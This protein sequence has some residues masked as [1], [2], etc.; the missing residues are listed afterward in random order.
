MLINEKKVEEGVQSTEVITIPKVTT[1]DLLTSDTWN[2]MVRA[3][4]SKTDRAGDTFA[5][6]LTINSKLTV[7]DNL[8]TKTATVSDKLTVKTATVDNLTVTN[9]VTALTVDNL[10]VT[11]PVT[12]L[13]VDNLT[14][15][16]ALSA[17]YLEVRS[18]V[19]RY[20]QEYYYYSIGNRNKEKPDIKGETGYDK[21][22]IECSIYA[23]KRIVA[24]EFNA[25]SDA[26]IKQNLHRSNAAADLATLM[27]LKVTDY[28]MIDTISK[29]NRVSKKLIAQ[30][31]AAVYPNAVSY[32]KDF[33]PNI[34]QLAQIENGFVT[35]SNP[36]LTIGDKV[37]LIFED[38][39]MEVRVTEIDENGFS[40]LAEQPESK[41]PNGAV[42]VFGKE[43]NDF[44]TLDYDA[45]TMLNTSATQAL[46]KQIN[47]LETSHAALKARFEALEMGLQKVRI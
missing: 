26:R 45:I 46:V 14:V 28:T 27:Q 31:V 30:E 16:N 7:D 17:G 12:A 25:I 8:T 34:Y 20:Q 29:G 10:T 1:G 4:N 38:Q 23:S 39:Q 24:S 3:I 9:P 37:R 41:L 43:V 33:I 42:F 2:Y 6:A 35:L 36:D 11:K 18:S 13:T 22:D 47:G 40:V 21:K 32:M 15:T 19:T 44:H 5:G